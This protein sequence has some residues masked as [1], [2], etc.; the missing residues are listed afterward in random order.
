MG[1]WRKK[2]KGK[3]N[4][5]EPKNDVEYVI[6]FINVFRIQQNHLWRELKIQINLGNHYII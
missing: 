1:K 3:K 5:N 6:V 4:K 2:S